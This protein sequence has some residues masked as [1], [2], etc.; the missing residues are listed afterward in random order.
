MPSSELKQI[1]D[2]VQ[3]NDW[4]SARQIGKVI[5][6]GKS[7]ANHYLYGYI[8][9]LFEK[10]G[11]T[12]P[13]W[14]V[15]S[16][17]AYGRMIARLNPAPTTTDSGTASAPTATKRPRSIFS[18]T[19]AAPIYIPREDLPAFSVCQSCDLPIQTTG[20]CGCS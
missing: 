2:F 17:D 6:G 8:D 3:K 12:P 1:F 7:W 14:K 18:V 11:L 4:S 19:R 5:P 15:V 16:P 20:R 13:Q 10:R 9:L